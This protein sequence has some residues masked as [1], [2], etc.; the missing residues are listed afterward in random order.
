[1]LHIDNLDEVIRIRNFRK[2]VLQLRQS[3]RHSPI[4]CRI[5]LGDGA[6]SDVFS[7]IGAQPAREVIVQ[8]CDLALEEYEAQLAVFGVTVTEESV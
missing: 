8:A 1:M 6:M 2:K 4:D 7:I 3:A 5:A